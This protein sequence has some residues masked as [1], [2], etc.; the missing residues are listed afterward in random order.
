MQKAQDV[1]PYVVMFLMAEYLIIGVYSMYHYWY[2]R[3][4]LV[5]N[6]SFHF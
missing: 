2:K 1:A 6:T 5:R 4:R 3:V